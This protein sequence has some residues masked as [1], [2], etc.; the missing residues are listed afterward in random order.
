MTLLALTVPGTPTF[1]GRDGMWVPGPGAP[2]HRG[3][4]LGRMWHST[5]IDPAHRR[6]FMMGGYP[7]AMGD[8]WMLDL[9]GDTP[10]WHLLAASSPGPGDR[11]GSGLVYDSSRDRLLLVGGGMT[12]GGQYTSDVWQYPLASGDGWQQ[13]SV[14]GQIP[15]SRCWHAALYDSLRDRLLI[16]C[17][18]TES[19]YLDD[20]WALS[21]TGTNQWVRL[22]TS[23]PS[24]GGRTRATTVYDPILD[25]IVR[26]GGKQGASSFN[27]VW[28]LPLAADGEWSQLSPS[29]PLPSPR[30]GC[31]GAFDIEQRA[32]VI[33][34]GVLDAGVGPGP[35]YTLDL[36]GTP[37][38]RQE[39]APS[40]PGERQN[41]TAVLDI[42]NDRVLLFG[43]VYI[44]WPDDLW[45]W[46]LTSRS[47]SQ[48]QTI[49]TPEHPTVRVS[50]GA[51]LRGST[52]QMYLIGGYQ[53]N[54]SMG[55]NDVWRLDLT[56]TPAWTQVF[57]GGEVLPTRQGSLV[58]PDEIGDRLIVFGGARNA[59][60]DI[61][62]MNFTEPASWS[63]LSPPGPLPPA[64]GGRGGVYDPVR[65][66]LIVTGYRETGGWD[67]WALPLDGLAPWTDL[68]SIAPA[69][70]VTVWGGSTVYDAPEDQLVLLGGSPNSE[71]WAL[72]LA[73]TPVWRQL[74]SGPG[75]SVRGQHAVALDTRRR[76]ILLTGGY[77]GGAY[78]AD[79][80]EFNLSGTIGWRQL[81]PT[82]ASPLPRG[83]HSAAY[84]VQNDRMVLTCGHNGSSLGD[85]WYLQFDEPTPVAVGTAQPPSFT[86]LGI[87][88]SPTSGTTVLSFVTPDDEPVRVTVFD[89]LGRR[90]DSRVVRG[91]RA[92]VCRADLGSESLASGVY[93]ALL[94]H[95]GQRLGQRFAVIR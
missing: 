67:V 35:T 23:E 15:P 90:L 80:W 74:Y 95:S 61:W 18:Q 85:T 40:L 65:R 10:T 48:Q 16:V 7:G 63:Q 54:G 2:G 70:V 34:S 25:R 60:N 56:G 57:P 59:S 87:G 22:A 52:S 9:A 68:T 92:Q 32:L 41:A 50:P 26:F 39:S 43:G 89:L 6:M 55:L 31:A 17:G 28:V 58:V 5:A 76:R 4:P 71:V 69:P 33:Y 86:L 46:S 45:A 3:R 53:D 1:A 91:T 51:A 19:I 82:G 72:G 73:G 13:L 36:S 14:A 62:V 44:S 84:D 77:A 21:L 49:G 64:E 42:T 37:S 94:E 81:A 30:N 83:S 38:W 93:Y 29:G 75:P 11:F 47:W 20:V 27:D 79:T 12:L 66:R 8:L 78:L 24:P 88:P